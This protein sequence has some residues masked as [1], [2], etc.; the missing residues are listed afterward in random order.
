MIIK[1]LFL[2]KSII[3]AL[4]LRDIFA[5]K[6]PFPTDAISVSRLIFV[7]TF[8]CYKK[9]QLASNQI[10][11]NHRHPQTCVNID[12]YSDPI[13]AKYTLTLQK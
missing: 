6:C 11:I 3:E 1:D 4:T 13:L 2:S 10:Y 7:A 9:R 12:R 8:H 5:P